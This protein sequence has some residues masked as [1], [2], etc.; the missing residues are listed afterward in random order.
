MIG[1]HHPL[2]IIA[3]SSVTKTLPFGTKDDVAKEIK[4]LV[5]NGPPT[6][7]MLGASSS[8]V[9]GT[10]RENIK[11]LMEGLLYYQEHGR[12]G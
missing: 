1:K 3:G 10:N 8:I 7:L 12:D 6:G 5:D 9:P 2:F 4:W 11:T